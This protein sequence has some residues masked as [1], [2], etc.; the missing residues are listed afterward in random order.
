L[1]DTK[2]GW[3]WVSS[4]RSLVQGENGVESLQ[5]FFDRVRQ[6]VIELESGDRQRRVHAGEKAGHRNL[7]SAQAR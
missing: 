1:A 5:E 3:Y 2:L 7:K 6:I 4:R